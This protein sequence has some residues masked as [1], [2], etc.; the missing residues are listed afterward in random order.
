MIAIKG[1]EMPESCLT[2][3]FSEHENI[4][5]FR[6][7]C[8]LT[9]RYLGNYGNAKAKWQSERRDFCPLVELPEPQE[10]FEGAILYGYTLGEIKD[11]LSAV[12]RLHGRT[13]HYKKMVVALSDL[14]TEKDRQIAELSQ[15]RTDIRRNPEDA[16]REDFGKES[17]DG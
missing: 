7:F 6:Y 11:L 17:K 5:E 10:P 15:I 8:K 1:M 12:D 4:D 3:L 9:E 13:D 16:Y 2:C 14:I